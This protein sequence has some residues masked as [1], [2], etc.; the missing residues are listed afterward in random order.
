MLAAVEQ[1]QN[2]LSDYGYTIVGAASTLP[3]EELREILGKSGYTLAFVWPSETKYCIR[4]LPA[5]LRSVT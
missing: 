3:L 1:T 2:K 5:F 4:R